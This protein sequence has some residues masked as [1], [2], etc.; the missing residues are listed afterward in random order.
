MLKRLLCLGIWIR[1][2]PWLVM[3]GYQKLPWQRRRILGVFQRNILEY[4]ESFLLHERT[5]RYLFILLY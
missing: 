2:D 4:Y 3:F 1:E 5:R